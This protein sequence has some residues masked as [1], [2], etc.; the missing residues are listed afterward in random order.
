MIQLK[1]HVML[2]YKNGQMIIE[3]GVWDL[4]NYSPVSNCRGGL[5]NR[6]SEVHLK[7]VILDGGSILK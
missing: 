4:N 2:W 1:F 6:G 7:S 3:D 5:I